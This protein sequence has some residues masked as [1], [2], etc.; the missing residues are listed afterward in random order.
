MTMPLIS[1][2]SLFIRPGADPVLFSFAGDHGRLIF[3]VSQPEFEVNCRPVTGF[4]FA[5][6]EAQ[7]AHP[8]GLEATLRYIH[9]ETGLVLRVL[10]QG[11]VSQ[12]LLRLRFLLS[13]DRPSGGQPYTLTKSNGA[14][15]LRY[16]TVRGRFDRPASLT[17]IQLSQLDPLLHSY[18][19][20]EETYRPD[21][22]YA[23]QIFPGPIAILHN[24]ETALLAA[25][26][27]GVETP[28]GFLAI[29]VENAPPSSPHGHVAPLL[30]GHE[31]QA[32]LLGLAL[33]A[34][35]GNYA[36]G[37]PLNP[38][39]WQSVWFELMPTAGSLEDLLP[40]YRQF[41]LDDLCPYPETRKPHI[42]YSTRN[43]QERQHY[44][45]HRP[46]LE[47]LNLNRILAEIE[48]CHRLG[49]DVFVIDAGW[50]DR[51][52]DW[53]VNTSRF[54][55]GLKKVRQL[56]DFYEMK[57]GVWFNPITAALNS[58]IFRDHPDWEMTRGDQPAWRGPLWETEESTRMCLV[59]GYAQFLAATTARL[60]H[61]LGVRY[62]KWGGIDQHGCDSPHHEHGT[63]RNKPEERVDCYTFELVQRMTQVVA[64]VAQTCPNLIIDLDI[65]A[66]GH[67]IG[68]GFLSVGKYSL[69][70]NGPDFS[71][72]DLPPEIQ[73]I[74]HPIS[75]FFH[76]GP[77]RP[78]ACR[79]EARFDRFIPAHLFLTHFLPD[80]PRLSQANNL[81]TLVLGG[82]G[83][84]GDLLSLNDSD[85]A[86]V[87]G[88][89]SRYKR[90]AASAARAYPLTRGFPGSSPE[91]YEKIDLAVGRGLVAFFTVL[92]GT[93]TH[94]TQPLQHLGKVQGADSWEVTPDKRLKLTVR[95][96]RNDA[97]VVFVG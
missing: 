81:A 31:A 77:A 20:G 23:G 62:F 46:Y 49:I 65:T 43:Y 73:I 24:G 85:L 26:E 71:D 84:W 89:L 25:Y 17:E 22:I 57:L 11:F 82:N 72:F 12:P 37:Q 69:V 7:G 63:I 40:R 70:N 10:L 68:L 61:D 1:L 50:F 80:P 16:F 56:L 55:D 18:A 59:S 45:N 51:A 3:T 83:L 29:S 15:H 96:N 13:E 42:F 94:L 44:L 8:R 27:H 5:G 4:T 67:P 52:G 38:Q 39:P 6:L 75:A 91:I 66:R 60:Y 64:Q 34:V 90:V 76:P 32:G 58:Q 95:L 86:I 54:P 36:D 47:S 9:I 88:V 35:K 79:S 53:A 14:D 74:P 97:R 30:S 33:R 92:P 19:P 93:F 48:V 21:Q 28:G 2:G 87:S 41:I 78:R